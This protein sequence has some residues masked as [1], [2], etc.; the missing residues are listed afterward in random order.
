MGNWGGAPP[1]VYKQREAS[2]ASSYESQISTLNF[3]IKQL[4]TENAELKLKLAEITAKYEECR[5][6][7]EDNKARKS[8]TS[9]K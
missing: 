1:W 5:K 9:G 2:M 7:S 6:L 4:E 8:K 3:R